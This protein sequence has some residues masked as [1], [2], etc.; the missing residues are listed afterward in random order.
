MPYRF[1]ILGPIGPLHDGEAVPPGP[2]KRRA[3]ITALLLERN[4]PVTVP[5]L[6][7]AMWSGRPPD[8][9]VRNVRAHAT[10][11]RRLLGGRLRTRAGAYELRV[12]DAEL[13]SAEFARLAQDG[14]H[15]ATMM[16]YAIWSSSVIGYRRR[17]ASP[18]TG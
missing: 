12:D 9:A 3:M 8:S 5:A 17:S 11:L 15:A 2:P 1:E 16:V 7:A 10:A 18:V 4:Q 13:D 6:I 14:R